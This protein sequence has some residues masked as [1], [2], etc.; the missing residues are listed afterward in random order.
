MAPS[1]SGGMPLK[2]V[3][4][5]AQTAHAKSELPSKSE[6]TEQS[7]SAASTTANRTTDDW[8]ISRE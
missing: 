5:D 8:D 3:A 7:Q 1:E 6:P 4:Y 2:K